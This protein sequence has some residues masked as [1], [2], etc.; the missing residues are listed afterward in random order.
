[1]LQPPYHFGAKR[2]EYHVTREFQK[3]AV[4]LDQNRLETPLKNMANAP[5]RAIEQLGIDAIELAHAFG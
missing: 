2:V 5:M 4:L 1:L 3:I